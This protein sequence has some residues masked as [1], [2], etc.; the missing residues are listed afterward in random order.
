MKHPLTD[1]R[2]NAILT[3]DRTKDGTF[4]YGVTT[5]KIFCQ[6]S[7]HSKAPKKTN[8]VIFKTPDEALEANFRPCKRCQPTGQKLTN[9]L[10]V[11]QIKQYL[12]NNFQQHLT[13][14][15]IASDCHGSVS[16]LQR[17]FKRI[18]QQSPTKYLAMIR[19]KHSQELLNTTDYSIKTI[20]IRCGFSS[21]TY[22]NTCFK[23]QFHQTPIAYRSLTK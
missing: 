19:L 13:L 21:D 8:V 9:E 14:D 6:P 23:K 16:N 17:T 20:A 18:T 15:T 10:W 5:T 22:F 4:Y 1:S 11:E 12:T 2:W 7:C 3:N